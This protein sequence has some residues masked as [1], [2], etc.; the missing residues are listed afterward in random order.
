MEIKVLCSG[1]GVD[2]KCGKVMGVERM[3]GFRCSDMGLSASLYS[4]VLF[5]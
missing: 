2:E 1:W 4:T 5:K 3:R